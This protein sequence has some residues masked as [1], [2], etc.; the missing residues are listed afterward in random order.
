MFRKSAGNRL[1]IIIGRDDR[2]KKAVVLNGP[3]RCYN[4]GII[5]TTGVGKTQLF[6]SMIYQDLMRIS[7]GTRMALTVIEP[8]GDLTG[9]VA[10]MCDRI[11]LK[12]VYIDPTNEHTDKFNVLQGDKTV[13][14]EATRSVLNTLF[15]SQQAFF[16]QVQQTLVR[17]TVLLLKEVHGDNIDILDV[18]KVMRNESKMADEINILKRRAGRTDLVQYFE[19]EIMG[20]MKEKYRQFAAGLRQ[21][22]EDI[23]GNELMRRVFAGSSDIDLDRHLSGGGVLIINTA[24][25]DLMKKMGEIFG[26]YMLIHI[27]F[28]VFRK[29]KEY[30]D[31][32]HALYIDE[33]PKYIG[34]D[35][36][37]EDF[38]AIGR[39]YG[40]FTTV[41][42]QSTSQLGL[43]LGRKESVDTVL[44]LLRNKIVFGGMDAGDAKLFEREFG[45]CDVQQKKLFY[46]SLLS[47][48]AP[49][50]RGYHIG[51]VWEPRYRY[52]E[53]M[54]LE[55]YRFIHRL[56]KRAR[57]QKP[58][59]ARGD[60]VR[61]E[62]IG[63]NSTMMNLMYYIKRNA[64]KLFNDKQEKTFYLR[65]PRQEVKTDPVACREDFWGGRD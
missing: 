41:A 14:A 24:M 7:K 38:L 30:W 17:N 63:S 43:K 19:N 39:K 5:G 3:D 49:F 65:S 31:V 1:D 55:E 60:L 33:L 10:L 23:G 50:A 12:Y 57:L 58:G 29:K 28:A 2:R 35:S 56:V 45:E 61:I 4:L 16:G 37:F 47:V 51:V 11:G 13:V 27:V 54:E 52:T 44:N 15:G 48:R 18:L 62:K 42:L 9:K 6:I 36:D 26:E 8:T 22:L 25:G 20:E 34:P 32:P 59:K 40:N 64:R 53:L 46:D 21:Q